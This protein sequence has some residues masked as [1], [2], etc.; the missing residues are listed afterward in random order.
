VISSPAEVS[1]LTSPQKAAGLKTGHYKLSTVGCQ[2]ALAL[3]FGTLF[4]ISSIIATHTENTRGGKGP[5]SLPA[6]ALPSGALPEME[7]A[8]AI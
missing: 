8:R 5:K 6:A 1:A 7:L 3:L 2:L 4:K